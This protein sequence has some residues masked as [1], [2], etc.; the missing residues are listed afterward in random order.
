LEELVKNIDE[1]IY[2]Q[3][4]SKFPKMERDVAF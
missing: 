1:K 4:T 2:Y 3:K